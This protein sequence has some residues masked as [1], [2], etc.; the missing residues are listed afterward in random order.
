MFSIVNSVFCRAVNL[1]GYTSVQSN[2]MFYLFICLVFLGPHAPMACG[3]SQAR[4]KI[5]AV[6][7]GHSR[8]T[9]EA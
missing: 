7:A 9:P 4:G 2:Y 6:A 5:G 3:G 8:P 1:L